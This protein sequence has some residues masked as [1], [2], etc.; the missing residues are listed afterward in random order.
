MVLPDHYLGTNI[1]KVQAQDSKIMWATHSGYYC[2]AEIKN[3]EKT[4]MDDGKIISQYGDGRRRYP[5]SFYPYIDTSAE[6]DENGVYEYQ[7]HSG[8][9]SWAI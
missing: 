5:S 2:K 4:L 6:L 1:K 3:L 7:H 8:V 9:L